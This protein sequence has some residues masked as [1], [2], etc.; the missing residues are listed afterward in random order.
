MFRLYRPSPDGLYFFALAKPLSAPLTGDP[1][2]LV[3]G[4][5]EA[6]LLDIGPC[7][8]DIT[9]CFDERQNLFDLLFEIFGNHADDFF[10]RPVGPKQ[11]ET[12]LEGRIEL[13]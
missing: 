6:P 9:G 8:L 3:P 12:R 10:I 1:Q 11:A 4:L 5:G 7:L 13:L 2:S